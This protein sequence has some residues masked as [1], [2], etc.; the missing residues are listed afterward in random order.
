MD[1]AP[2]RV[3]IVHA[4]PSGYWSLPVELPAGA[5]VAD[6]LAKARGD[7][8]FDA[9]WPRV[10]GLAIFGRAVGEEALLHEGDRIELLRPLL[11]DPKQARRERASPVKR[12]G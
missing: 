8:R 2:I 4:T 9:A 7:A 1:G 11:A 3:T 6:A 10:A 5:D 12:R